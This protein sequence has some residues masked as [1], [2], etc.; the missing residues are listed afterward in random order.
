MANRLMFIGCLLFAFVLL[1]SNVESTPR[2]RDG[3]VREYYPAGNLKLE[4][5]FKDERLVR[6]R[7]Y[8][9][10]GQLLSEKVYKN[11][12]LY[13]TRFFYDNG[14]LKSVWHHSTGELRYYAETGEQRGT[15]DFKQGQHRKRSSY[16]F[17]GE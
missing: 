3:V 4:N 13:R 14:R 11:G 12:T 10:N 1:A 15:V 2:P 17:S 6:Q 9:E 7:T 16:I 8:Y 5:V